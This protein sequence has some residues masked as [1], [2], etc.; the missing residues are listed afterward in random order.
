LL[1]IFALAAFAGLKPN[2]CLF[3]ALTLALSPLQTGIALGN[4]SILVVS[5][6]VLAVWAAGR[7]RAYLAGILLAIACCLKPQ[8]GMWFILY[9]GLRKQWR[10]LW[11]W[12]AIGT[13]IASVGILRLEIS[14]V[15]WL[16]GFLRNAREFVVV[17]R[18][19]DFTDADPIRFT[20]INLQV[21]FYALGGSAVIARLGAL[22]AGVS[23]LAA[24]VWFSFK[25]K[26]PELL[27]LA[28]LVM[29]SVLPSY[30]RNYDA[31]V[32]IF[33]LCWMLSE[34]EV[35]SR[36]LSKWTSLLLLPFLL[37]GPSLLQRLAA[38]GKIPF[39][40]TN[41]WWW[42]TVVMPHQIWALLLLCILLLWAMAGAN[43]QRPLPAN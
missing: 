1:A 4:L 43:Q 15:Q 18:T 35:R 10:I 23:L 42:N 8:L 17:T 30:H 5:L 33:P 27:T 6:C 25:S 32:L 11:V 41:G 14:G 22:V 31:V 37:P 19:V 9:Y 40:I 20:M 39:A 16:A 21:L 26:S 38:E 24:W 28:A 7:K 13:A 34:S 36:S 12:A 2:A 3:A 29:I